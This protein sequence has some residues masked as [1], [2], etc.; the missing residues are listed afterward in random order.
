MLCVSELEC[1]ERVAIRPRMTTFAYNIR[2]LVR[3]EGGQVAFGE[4]VGVS[5]GTVSRW[6]DTTK[7]QLPKMSTVSGVTTA[8]GV[9]VETLF[10]VP[11][12]RWNTEGKP[13]YPTD[14]ELAILIAKARG[15]IRG[16]ATFD[17]VPA[18]LARQL[19]PELERILK[20]RAGRS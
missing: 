13:L 11:I 6:T 17:E 8:Y 7:P 12:D 9:S 14:D 5:Q 15:R 2:E 19:A 3:R 20:E 16:D 1:L 10:H 18:E 4:K